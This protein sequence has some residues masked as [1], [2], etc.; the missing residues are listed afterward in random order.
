MKCLECGFDNAQTDVCSACNAA[1]PGGATDLRERDASKKPEAWQP[2]ESAPKDGTIVLG[3]QG[4]D[5][6]YEVFEM[7]YDPPYG[8]RDPK[9]D[10]GFDPAAWMP[11]PS[12]PESL[13]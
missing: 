5:D 12:S 8:W 4:R 13:K 10:G 2:I 1:L 6:D 11:R 7:V 3:C 9:W